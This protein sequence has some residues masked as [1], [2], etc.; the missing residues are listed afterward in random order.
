MTTHQINEHFTGVPSKLKY[1]THALLFAILCLLQCTPPPKPPDAGVFKHSTFSSPHASAITVP[2]SFYT[3]EYGAD[4]LQTL[5][6]FIPHVLPAGN[7]S[8][9]ILMHIHGGS[10]VSG[11]KD[12]IYTQASKMAVVAEALNHGLAF[13]NIN[14]RLLNNSDGL[15]VL[16]KC[17]ADVR[18]ALQF[19]RYHAN[20][21][22]I[23]L[24][25]DKVVLWGASAGASSAF[26]LAFS[27]EMSTATIDPVTSESTRV[28][29]V[30][31]QQTQAT[32][33]PEEWPGIFTNV[34]TDP[35]GMIS[36]TLNDIVDI[37]GVPRVRAIYGIPT[38]TNI[39]TW[40]AANQPMLDQL[41]FLNAIGPDDPPFWI[42]HENI[43]EELPNDVTLIPDE[44]LNHHPYHSKALLDKATGV[45]TV[46]ARIV[47]LNFDNTTS[48][49]YELKEAIDF[50]IVEAVN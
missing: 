11:N 43:P 8:H 27:D 1:T 6:L 41:D 48:T 46:Y 39:S 7:P 44:V 32:L 28:R 16:D 29:A 19:I 47:P 42:T 15:N 17:L 50:L 35:I 9:P 2:Y 3:A 4:D 20:T 36:L 49:P 40:L 26:F 22:G 34:P 10:F 38:G 5:D 31:A 13:V 23:S 14:Y 12:N 21:P 25:K 30:W 45:I 33:D 18:Y 37:L 24:N